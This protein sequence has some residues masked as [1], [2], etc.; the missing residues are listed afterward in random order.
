[1]NLVVITD[2]D[3]GPVE[4][5][6]NGPA[7]NDIF[8]EKI[9]VVCGECVVGSDVRIVIANNTVVDRVDCCFGSA[10]ACG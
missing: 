9:R 6:I 5:R 7:S 8:V 10:A 2:P 1:V 3:V 4:A